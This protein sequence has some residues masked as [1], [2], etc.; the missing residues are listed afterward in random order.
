L[1]EGKA[2]IGTTLTIGHAE[3][4]E[5]VGHANF[6]W[7]LIDTE[8]TPMGYESVQLCMQAMS[9]SRAVPLVRVAWND[10]VLIKRALDIGA[11][12]V[13]VPWVNSKDDA[14]RAVKAVRYSP[15]GLRGYGPRR[16]AINDPDYVETAN[17]EIYLGVQIETQ[18]AID[19]IDEILSVEGI[20][21]ALVGPWDLSLSLGII[22]QLDSPKFNVAME[23]IVS[24][25]KRHNLVAGM[26]AVD[27][28]KRRLDQGFRLLNVGTDYFFLR[29]AVNSAAASAR[30]IFAEY[31]F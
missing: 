25:C 18:A 22:G 14:M 29:N 4:A 27:D 16:A 17:S 11:Y 2:A 23:K 13:I 1:S 3:T 7:V 30:K 9:F 15:A 19:S 12:G 6:D 5:L 21:A 20:D 8:H 24:A 10:L 28:V 26:L 31:K